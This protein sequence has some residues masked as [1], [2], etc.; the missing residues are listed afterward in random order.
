MFIVTCRNPKSGI[1]GAIKDPDIHLRTVESYKPHQC[2]LA[3]LFCQKVPNKSGLL[4]IE[5]F[6]HH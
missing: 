5:K 3:C 2:L 4:V 1:R 6:Q